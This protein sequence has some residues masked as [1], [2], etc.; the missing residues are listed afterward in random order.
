MKATSVR[1]YPARR[2]PAR[3]YPGLVQLHWRDM[4]LA[5]LKS[6]GLEFLRTASGRAVIAFF[7]LSGLY[8]LVPVV[9]SDL[10]PFDSDEA[11]LGLMARHLA[12]GDFPRF[13]YGQ[14]YGGGFE[15]LLAGALER[16]LPSGIYVF[17]LAAAVLAFATECFFYRALAATTTS[18]P[19]RIAATAMLT[20]GGMTYPRFM[21]H[22]YGIHLNN[23]FIFASLLAWSSDLRTLPRRTFFVG[24]WIGIGHW[25][26]PF[27]WVFVLCL[28]L[29]RARQWRGLRAMTLRQVLLLTVGF[30][31]GA[32]PR[33]VHSYSPASWY[34]PYQAGGF[35]MVGASAIPRRTMDLV[36]ETLPR[37]FFGELHSLG[38]VGTVAV[39]M[40]AGVAVVLLVVAA[41]TCL[42]D[43]RQR[44]EP[45]FV[46]ATIFLLAGS[47]VAL[48]VLNRLVFD[49]GSRYLWPF[50]F[51]VALAWVMALP[52]LKTASPSPRTLHAVFR[53]L[54]FAVISMPFLFGA[55]S[56]FLAQRG[57][58]QRYGTPLKRAIAAQALWQ[59]CRVGVADYWYGYSLS[60]LTQEELRLAPIYTPRI[61]SYAQAARDAMVAGTRYCAVL[62]LSNQ[63]QVVEPNRRLYQLLQPKAE[64]IYRYPGSIVL[65]VLGAPPAKGG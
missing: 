14:T 20:L 19:A 12:Q 55:L 22:L 38:T 10:V 60:L 26:S 2:Y 35:A 50:Q 23:S 33:I 37:Y 18:R 15:A 36:F 56:L 44:R 34:A 40:G 54:P 62:D 64:R 32:L 11:V 31:I 42:R 43:W 27:V 59:G 63:A 52:R 7:L 6:R 48:V 61:L 21:S 9:F 1:R 5:A 16:I 28:L 58:A 24:L 65:L 45:A 51:A 49:D 47:S 57:D 46:P 30:A 25:V 29:A 17:R 13:A 39:A 53:P 4:A 41:V 3:R 8:K